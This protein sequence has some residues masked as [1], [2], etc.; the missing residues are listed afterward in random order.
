MDRHTS[1]R[2]V[3][4]DELVRYPRCSTITSTTSLEEMDE[5]R[6]SDREVLWRNRDRWLFDADDEPS[7]GH[8]GT[9][10]KDRSLVDEF[11]PKCVFPA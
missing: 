7:V 9:D 11:H 8:G 3:R 10:E 4:R 6:V 5:Q 2:S 1:R